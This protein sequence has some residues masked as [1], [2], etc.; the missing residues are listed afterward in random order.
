VTPV[1]LGLALVFAA[2]APK[3]GPKP[4]VAH[5]LVGTWAVESYTRAGKPMMVGPAAVEM[6]ADRWVYRGRNEA[7]SYL[8]VG[9][10]QNAIDVWLPGTDNEPPP[11]ARG[12]YALVGDAL[13]I[14]S[15]VN[16]ERPAAVTATPAADV[17]VMVLKRKKD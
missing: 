1:A 15:R 12:V 11:T 4:A 7:E 17:W 16:G 10:E 5:P 2:P 6:T 9:A 13:T 8:A 3:A 14:H